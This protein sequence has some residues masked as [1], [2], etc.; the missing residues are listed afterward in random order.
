MEMVRTT[1]NPRLGV[2]KPKLRRGGII[3]GGAHQRAEEV[4]MNTPEAAH[5]TKARCERY[6][7]MMLFV[8]TALSGCSAMQ[9]TA[10]IKGP[11]AQPVW[12]VG[13]EWAYRYETPSG[14]GTFVW[15]LDRMET[16]AIVS[17]FVLTA[18]SPAL[19]SRVAVF[20]FPARGVGRRFGCP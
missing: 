14:T 10:A 8:A 18:A 2:T 17:H 7:T 3:D 4:H 13:N 9:G 15:R 6:A 20:G 12:K 11:I 19:F 1:R 16:L 5:R